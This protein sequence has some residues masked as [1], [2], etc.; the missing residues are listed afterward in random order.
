MTRTPSE[1]LLNKVQRPGAYREVLISSGGSTIVL[2]VWDGRPGQTAVVFLPGTMTH[3]LF[4]EEFLDELNL[5][6]LT[7][8]GVHY[9]GHG[10]S[11]RTRRPLSFDRLVTNARDVV[12]WTRHA[13]QG[14]P[15]AVLGSSQGGIVAMALAAAGDDLDLLIAHNVLDPRLASSIE[16][17][18]FPKRLRRIYPTAV[19]ALLGAGRV[20]P[21]D[22]VQFDAYL[23]IKRVSRDKANA[24]YFYTDPLGLRSYS[25]GFMA[26]LL[27]ADLTGM[28]DSS[29]TCPVLV[30]AGR[31]DPLFPLPYTR[32]VYDSIVAPH[33][34][35]L[36]LESKVHLLFNEDLDVALRP[37]LDRLAHL[38]SRPSYTAG[39]ATAADQVP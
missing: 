13:F 30:V 38:E 31:G 9:Q 20:V 27:S 39:E 6:G 25:L 24:E 16:V 37:L 18:R 36:I 10:K 34:E 22:P 7:V 2:S 12:T 29:I 3:P 5:T 28:G 17:T 33:K 26:T 14:A 35:L 19:R 21:R 8:V 32:E 11:P 15:V 4:Y 23:D 1:K